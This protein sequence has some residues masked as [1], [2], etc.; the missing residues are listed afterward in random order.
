MVWG[1]GWCST[2]QEILEQNLSQILIKFSMNGKI[3]PADAIAVVNQTGQDANGKD[4]WCRS[5]A[6]V[7]DRWPSG[8]HHLETEITFKSKIN[9]G[10]VDYPAGSIRNEYTVFVP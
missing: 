5:A 7:P 9:D 3:V 2:S 4:V 8:E 6:L 10:M 1:F